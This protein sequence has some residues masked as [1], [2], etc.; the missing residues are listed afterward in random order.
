MKMCPICQVEK[1]KDDFGKNNR[2]K[3]GLYYCCKEC[4]Q[5]R[6]S[7]YKIENRDRLNASEREK[8]KFFKETNEYKDYVASK[9]EFD[10][11]YREKNKERIRENQKKHYNTN[12]EKYRQYLIDNRDEI[13]R[14]RRI[15]LSEKRK[16]PKFRLRKNISGAILKALKK[17]NKKKNF[18]SWLKLPYSVDDLIKHLEKQF[19]PWMNW[20]NYGN[21][22]YGIRRW[23]ID[24]IIPQNSLQFESIDEENF[25]KCWSL[26]NLRP[27]EALEN[28]LKSNKIEDLDGKKTENYDHW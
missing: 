4:A 27:L 17:R 14:K 22:Q 10:K 2:T 6:N 11:F 8:W 9:K 20:D 24:H 28:I 19:E 15:Y 1:I 7:R 5:V 18:S 16:D 23:N 13:N 12:K 25:Q 21:Y 26:E 3:D